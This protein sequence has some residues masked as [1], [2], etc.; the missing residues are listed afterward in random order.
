MPTPNPKPTDQ[1]VLDDFIEWSGGFTPAECDEDQLNAYATLGC[2]FGLPQHETEEALT[3]LMAQEQQAE[4][5]SE[6]N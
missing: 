6:E 4:I 2:S 1:Q 3:R 5:D